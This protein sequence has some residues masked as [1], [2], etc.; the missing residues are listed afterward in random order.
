MKRA[1]SVLE[2]KAVSDDAREITGIA[3]TPSPD[4]MGD[5]VEPLG[6]EFAA[7]LP[8]LWQHQHDQPVGHVRFGKPTAKGIPFTATLPKIEEPG[9]L[10]ARVDLAWQSVKALLVRAVSIGLPLDEPAAR[11][12]GKG[13]DLGHQR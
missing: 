9:E 6:A 10:Q 2:I 12:E 4:R 1:Y 7:E 3:T 8:L 13:N 11:S 5:V